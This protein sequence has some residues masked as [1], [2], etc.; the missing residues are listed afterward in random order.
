MCGA[1]RGENLYEKY[2]DLVEIHLC[3][4]QGLYFLQV[5]LAVDLVGQILTLPRFVHLFIMFLAE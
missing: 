2:I 4:M 3:A 5:L 1:N